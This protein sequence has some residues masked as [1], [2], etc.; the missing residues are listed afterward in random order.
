MFLAAVQRKRFKKAVLL[1]TLTFV[2]AKA[3]YEINIGKISSCHHPQKK[4]ESKKIIKMFGVIVA[5]RPV[6]KDMHLHDHEHDAA[7]CE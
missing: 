1:L 3:E 4:K 7:E 6:S 5:G 2:A